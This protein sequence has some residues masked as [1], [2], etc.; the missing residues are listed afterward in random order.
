MAFKVGQNVCA[1]W[2]S[3]WY[4]AT[5]TAKDGDKWKV[6]YADGDNGSVAATG[7]IAIPWKPV[8]KK[9]DKVLASWGGSA[10]W[11]DGTVIEIGLSQMAFKV[12]WKDGSTPSW[13]P[14]TKIVT[15]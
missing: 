14:A 12:K 15:H 7:L 4:G 10:K 9:G 1:K 11:Y 13:V 3:S 8:L 5:I 6:L 2:G